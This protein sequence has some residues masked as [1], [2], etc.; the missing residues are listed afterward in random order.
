MISPSY[1]LGL[2]F[3]KVFDEFFFL[4]VYGEKFEDGRTAENNW[5]KMYATQGLTLTAIQFYSY[6]GQISVEEALRHDYIAWT[7]FYIAATVKLF[8]ENKKGIVS[9]E[10]DRKSA[11]A[12]HLVVAF[13]LVADL[14]ISPNTIALLE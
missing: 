8:V 4:K 2:F 13:G 7:L 10:F 6:L 9:P 1:F 11:Q 3:P 12:F 14:I 5:K